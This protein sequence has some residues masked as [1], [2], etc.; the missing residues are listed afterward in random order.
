MFLYYNDTIMD[1]KPREKLVNLGP[2]Q[3]EDHELL[4]LVLSKGSSKENVFYLFRRLLKNFDREELLA[5]KN[6]SVL[7]KSL[8]AKLWLVLNLEKDFFTHQH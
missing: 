4:A 6:F 8:L 7:P 1:M 2:E 3:L 5:Q